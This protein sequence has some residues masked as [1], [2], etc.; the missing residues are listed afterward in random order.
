MAR[1]GVLSV[2][3]CTTP[4]ASVRFQNPLRKHGRRIPMELTTEDTENHR[5]GC[6]SVLCV[7]P[8]SLW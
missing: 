5:G 3:A 4:E 1:P 7:P 2:R 6:N 8:R